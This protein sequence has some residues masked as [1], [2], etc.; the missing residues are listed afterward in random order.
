MTSSIQP[1]HAITPSIQFRLKSKT[2]SNHQDASRPPPPPIHNTIR[3][4]LP[5]PRNP[6]EPTPLL[7]KT[8][9]R[10][11]PRPNNHNIHPEPSLHN[12]P[13]RSAAIEHKNT[14][15]NAAIT[16][17]GARADSQPT[18]SQRQAR[19]GRIP[20]DASRGPDNLPR[21]RADGCVYDT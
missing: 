8:P 4:C 12:R 17:V 5:H 14:A 19:G 13:T 16:P 6:H 20:P 9:I 18:H 10:T 15:A 3:P 1:K 11:T 2:K 21:P 7:Q